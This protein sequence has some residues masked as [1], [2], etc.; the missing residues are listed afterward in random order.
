MTLYIPVITY[1]P[2]KDRLDSFLSLAYAKHNVSENLIHF[3]EK[4]LVLFAGNAFVERCFSINNESLAENLHE[5]SLF[6]QR[7]V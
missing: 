2:Q 7:A 1:D 4:V 6:A 5:N 3:T